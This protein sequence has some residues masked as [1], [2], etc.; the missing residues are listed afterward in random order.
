MAD[1]GFSRIIEVL[2]AMLIISYFSMTIPIII[3]YNYS[4]DYFHLQSIAF[5]A[6][7][8]LDSSGDLSVIV[9]N[10]DWSL[11]VSY[12]KPLIP[13]GLNFNLL[14]YDDNHNLIFSYISNSKSFNFMVNT[15]FILKFRGVTR[16]I[17]LQVWM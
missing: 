7:Y 17:V 6:L 11:L 13:Q 16:I 12:I 14:V 3:N 5:N 9:Y 2:L 4:M 15:P 1:R 8:T 10:G